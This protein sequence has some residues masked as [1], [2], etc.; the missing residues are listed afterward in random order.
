MLLNENKEAKV[1]IKAT[2]DAE[3]VLMRCTFCR[4]KNHAVETCYKKLEADRKGKPK[5]K[6]SPISC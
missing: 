3:K 1:F 2:E 5:V 4:K 6:E